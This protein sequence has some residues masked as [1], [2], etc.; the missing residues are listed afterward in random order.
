MLETVF[1]SVLTATA[2]SP[3]AMGPFLLCTLVSLLLGA[4]I[5]LSHLYRSSTTKSFVVTLALLPAIVQVVIMLVNGNLGTGVAV[6][7]AFS[8]VRFRSVPGSAREICSIFLAMAVGLATGMGYL[9][10]AGVFTLVLCLVILLYTATPFGERRGEER[11]LK[12]TI[13]E[14]LDYNG[15][16]DDLFR[17]YLKRWTLL[18]V[19][20]TNLGS[21]FKLDYRVELRD[22]RQEKAFL[23]E[24]RCRNGN[25]EISCGRMGEEGLAL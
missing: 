13:P 9:A 5:A 10:A 1:S 20:T 25:L 12:V 14:G 18:Q 15:V 6:M 3:V 4:L 17:K 7:G 19:R 11:T 2:A 8:L 21:L 23:D 16:F 22:P 24:L